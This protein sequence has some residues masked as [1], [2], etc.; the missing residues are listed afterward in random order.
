MINQC[1]VIGRVG[2]DP[3]MRKTTSGVAVASFPVAVDTSKRG[4]T[5]N[6]EP[7]WFR[8]IRLGQACGNCNSAIQEGRSGVCRWSG[9]ASHLHRPREQREAHDVAPERI[10]CTAIV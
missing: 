1:T 3:Q 6:K 8:R 9:I 10:R 2:R 5:E 7:E 4:P